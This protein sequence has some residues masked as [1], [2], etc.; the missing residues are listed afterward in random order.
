M[1]GLSLVLLLEKFLTPILLGV[2]TLLGVCVPAYFK[3]KESKDKRIQELSEGQKEFRMGIFDIGKVY[4]Y[5]DKLRRDVPEV[6]RVMIFKCHNSFKAPKPTGSL[7]I[8]ALFEEPAKDTQPLLADVQRIPVDHNHLNH[9][10]L[11]LLINETVVVDKLIGDGFMDELYTIYN[12]EWCK[13]KPLVL[14]ED[15][16]VY[17]GVFFRSGSSKDISKEDKHK[18]RF[19]VNNIKNIMEKYKD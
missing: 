4:S 12:H 17:V 9:I 16:L 10:I 19:C 15:C 1:D 7:Y 8:T 18:I 13:V 14:Q 2:L 3:Y 6:N 11:P 5:M